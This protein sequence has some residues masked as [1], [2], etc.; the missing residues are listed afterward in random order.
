MDTKGV[1]KSRAP[2]HGPEVVT[3]VVT[4]RRAGDT[5]EAIG[6]AMGLS[7]GAVKKI[8]LNAGV[9]LPMEE[10]QA[11]AY[12]SKLARNPNAMADMRTARTSEDFERQR[13][14]VTATWARKDLREAQGRR[15]R[16]VPKPGLAKNTVGD[17]L[18]ACQRLGFGLEHVSGTPLVPEGLLAD[19]VNAGRQWVV[20]CHCG[21]R[22]YP[23]L[24]DVL[25]GRTRSCG[26]VR[27]HAEA[28]L[29]AFVKSLV[30]DTE[31]SENHALIAPLCLDIVVPSKR[32]AIEYCGLYWHGEAL[33]G[34]KARVQHRH[35]LDLVTDLPVG[36]RLVTIFEHEWVHTRSRVQAYLRAILDA[37][38]RKTIGA[39]EVETRMV[40]IDEARDFLE[41]YHLQG[42]P[43]GDTFVHVGLE[44]GGQLQAVASFRPYVLRGEGCWELSRYCQ[45]DDVRVHG[46]LL[47]CV[48]ALRRDRAEVQ[49]VV[50]FSDSRW[51]SGRLYQASGF[52]LEAVLPPSYWYSRRGTQGP[53]WHKSGFRKE[54]LLSQLGWNDDHGLTEWNLAQ[55]LGYDRI[56]DCGGRRWFLSLVQD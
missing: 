14:S 22:F 21:T 40:P 6:T 54:K 1:R 26:C 5:R 19:G 41:A 48:T 18:G 2:K 44:A 27:S 34:V 39:R 32:V 36:W 20:I 9:V 37:G 47:K 42:A 30:T 7:L 43:R 17:V 33:G 12:H 16:G 29:R 24:H 8:L 50:T 15:Q 35:K 38:S 51:S 55:A 45:R 3:Q 46:G 25:Y 49:G 10:R 31:D 28:E 4:R 23:S 56:W 53:C 52:V 13:A 11:N